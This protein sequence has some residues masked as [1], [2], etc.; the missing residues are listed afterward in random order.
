MKTM[1]AF[2]VKD[3]HDGLLRHKSRVCSKGYEQIPGVDFTESFAPV[4]TDT[5][6][7][8]ALCI[9]LY[10]A[11]GKDGL[12]FV[13]EMIDILAAFLEGNMESPTF[14]DWPAGMLEMG[15]ATQEDLKKFCLQ[16]LKNMYGNVD[17]AL[18][19]FKT[20]SAH[21]MGP[22]MKMEQ[23]L[24][25]PCVFYKRDKDSK[26]VIIAVCF[27]DDTLLVGT[28][29]EVKWFKRGIKKRFKY[30]DLGKIC[31]HLGIWYEEKYDENGEL[32]LEATMPKMVSDIIKLMEKH[33][34]EAVKTQ[35]IPGTQG[36]CTYK[37]A[38]NAVD[39]EMYQ[40]IVG[41]IMYLV[42]KLFA[43][44]SNGAREMARQFGNPGPDHWR[45][46]EKYVGYLKENEKDVKLA[47]QRPRELRVVSNVDSNYAMNKEDRRSVSGHIHTV[48]GTIVSWMSNT[49]QT[50]ALSSCEAEYISLA[51]GAQEVKFLQML[52]GEI[53][54]CEQPGIL[55]EDN[56]GAIFL[57]K[58]L[59]VGQRTK[60][61]DLHWHY[62]RGMRNMGEIEADFVRSEDNKLDICTKN[63]PFKLLKGF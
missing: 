60:H 20:Y 29:E 25:D 45:E 52:L 8:T 10:Y 24:A 51:S 1:W 15:F 56:T 58:N 63:L 36:E 7:R 41:K 62:I 35:D 34:G 40:K 26:T 22:M 18:R 37:W 4:A 39:P 9:Y 42:C 32:Y 47:Y 28:K 21:L 6:V 13:C 16:L 46:L 38:G 2:Q 53:M 5:T 12:T 3:E 14:I 55:L 30:K 17:A 44:G 57:L 33:K 59:H 31:K 43:E 50:V 27:V 19:F 11:Q 54:Y 61:I 23:S 49:Q 48:G